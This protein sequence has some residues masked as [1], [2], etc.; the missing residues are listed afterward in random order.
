[1]SSGESDGRVVRGEATRERVL[2]AARDVLLERGFAQ[3]S[4]RAVAERAAVR[5]SLV[6]Y[7]FGS[8][9]QLL[10]DVLERENE[11]LLERQHGL[12]ATPGPLVNKWRTACEFLD[13]DLRS[14]YVRVL[15]ELWAAGLADQTLAAR[16]R[17]AMGAWRDLL[18]SVAAEWITTID[19]DPPLTPKALATLVTNVF[20]GIE[21]E[22]LAGVTED[23]APHREV[24]DALGAVIE[25]WEPPR[26]AAAT[27]PKSS[28]A[29]GEAT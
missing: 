29:K 20:Q 18:E 16:W 23:E 5:L 9:H 7:H 1:M 15:W 27:R 17:S 4:T 26:I 10:I 3:T 2:I 13:E 19:L 22:L 28:K 6:H 14:G 8:K 21:I 24:L 11:L 25:Q 12:Y